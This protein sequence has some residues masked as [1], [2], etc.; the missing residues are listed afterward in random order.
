MSFIDK[1]MGNPAEPPPPSPSEVMKMQKKGL[2]RSKRDLDRQ[3]R[4][5]ERQ[6]KKLIQEIKSLASKGQNASV[7]L[8]AKELVRL[9]GQKAQLV[10]AKTTV[11]V[12][13]Y[14]VQSAKASMS[15]QNS[16]RGAANAMA[17]ANAM[18]SPAQVQQTMM[19]FERQ[20]MMME[21]TD[22]MLDELLE[23]SVEEEQADALV[24]AVFDE[25]GLDLEAQ[26]LPA[27]RTKLPQKNVKEHEEDLE[28]LH[29]MLNAL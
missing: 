26:M 17:T 24:S 15:V 29:A 28:E 14:K 6:E 3:M 19:E 25:I 4:G 22:E 23:D 27:P 20:S 5:L 8:M 16:M 11:G 1:L 9:R 2:G 7:K 21:A 13:Q 18:N 10:K 12:V